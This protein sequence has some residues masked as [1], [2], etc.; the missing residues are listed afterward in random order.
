[1]KIDSKKIKS[2]IAEKEM[3]LSA[4]A[5]SIE[6][7]KQGLSVILSKGSCGTVNAGKIAKGLNIPVQQ[8]I[9]EA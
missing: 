9:K 3:T 1:M 6:M 2:L 4:F 8:I 5:E 7:T